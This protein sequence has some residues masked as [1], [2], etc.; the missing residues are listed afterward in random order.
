MPDERPYAQLQMVW[1][2]R[3]LASPPRAVVPPGYVMRQ[4]GAADADAYLALMAKAGFK[5]WDHE[6]IEKVL[7]F[8]LPG[9][10]FLVEHTPTGRLV[11]TAMARHRPVEGHPGGGELSWVAADPAHARKGLGMAVCAA[12][13]ARFLEAGYRRIYLLTDDWR[14]PAI[15]LYL[16][17]GFEPFLARD[18][19]ADRWAAVLKQLGESAKGNR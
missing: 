15:R 9:G 12:V 10:W 19:M 13:I 2:E 14:L 1:P 18:D 8:V 17:L 3:L 11:A 16:Q 5:S 4:L 7:P 6:Q